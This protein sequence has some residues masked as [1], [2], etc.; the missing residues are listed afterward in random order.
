[1]DDRNFT[2]LLY[3]DDMTIV[4]TSKDSIAALKARSIEEFDI[5]ILGSWSDIRAIST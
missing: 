1:M 4:D 2:I 5:K 3:I